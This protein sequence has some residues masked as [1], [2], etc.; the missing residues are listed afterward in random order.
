[1]PT[2]TN[3]DVERSAL[4]R[5]ALILAGVVALCPPVLSTAGAE[6]LTLRTSIV[7]ST[8]PATGEVRFQRA[9]TLTV[10][11]RGS[12]KEPTPAAAAA[13]ADDFSALELAAKQGDATAAGLFGAL[14][15]RCSAARGVPYAA[16]EGRGL[17]SI[18][19]NAPIKGNDSLREYCAQRTTDEMASA[20]DW[21]Q[22]G[23]AGGD[24]ES[25]VLLAGLYRPGTNEPI[26][27]LTAAW[28]QGS[29][30]SLKKLAV[31]YQIRSD[32]PNAQDRDAVMSLA[33]AWL[34]TKLNE[35]A[36]RLHS[37]QSAFVQALEKDL[38]KR[39]ENA[40]SQEQTE[41]IAAARTM[42]STNERCCFIP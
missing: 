35:S 40:S 22:K 9:D 23:A 34:H 1:M 42:L 38:A 32:G 12:A 30:S 13:A 5:T 29:I 41:A 10:A 7:P 8:V 28:Q 27:L 26:E 21:V 39:L 11:F 3:S 18:A 6:D 36:F 15:I 14:L 37:G 20:I 4:S 24:L 19:K 17:R 31:A 2:T 33:S 25:M 16:D